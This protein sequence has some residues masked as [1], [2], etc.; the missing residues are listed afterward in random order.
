[1]VKIE[2]NHLNI[3]LFIKKEIINK[4]K[5]YAKDM[6]VEKAGYL[7]I[8][9]IKNTNEYICSDI[10]SPHKK[11]K[12]TPHRVKMSL[13]HKWISYK[14]QK[15]NKFLQQIG[16]YHTHPKHFGSKISPYDSREFIKKSRK[17]LF[18]IFIIT[19]EIQMSVYIYSYGKKIKEIYEF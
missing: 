4:I 15:Q 17:Y 3:F 19:T 11:D 7:F 6:L 1:M 18:S 10:T 12:V 9:K 2:I 8:K 13:A 14:I 16:F 5:S